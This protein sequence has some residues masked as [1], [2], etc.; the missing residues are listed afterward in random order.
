MSNGN[1]EKEDSVSVIIP[2]NNEEGNIEELY[3]RLKNVLN[4]INRDYELIFVD[5]GSKDGTFK[6]LCNI[7]DKKECRIRIIRFEK[8][9]GQSASLVAGIDLA[10]G[11]I[12]LTLDGDLQHPPEYIPIFLEYIDS[13]YEL[14]SGWKR[15][16]MDNIFARKFPSY[17][18]NKLVKV[19]FRA[20]IHDVCS[21][22]RAYK[23]EIIRDIDLFNGVHRFLPVLI[24]RDIPVVEVEVKCGKRVSGKSHYGLGRI[25]EVFMDIVRIWCVKYKNKSFPKVFYSIRELKV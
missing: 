7:Y 17:V 8:N 1:L 20:K 13:G 25:K 3:I 4:S 14:V 16:R 18:I 15:N 21:S 12:I 11:K 5:D 23:K 19:L 6:K 22:Y 10:K 9:F 2:L 24:N